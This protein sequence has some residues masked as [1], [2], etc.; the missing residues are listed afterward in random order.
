MP[1]NT[2]IDK[3]K[4]TTENDSI[5][6]NTKKRG[7]PP[8]NTKKSIKRSKKVDEVSDII[9]E[10]HNDDISIEFPKNYNEIPNIQSDDI[11]INNDIRKDEFELYSKKNFINNTCTPY[12][13]F[14]H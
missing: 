12:K 4:I 7:R 10:N 11:K 1:P 9:L 5:V 2:K 3:S 8:K 13:I 14:W 6:N